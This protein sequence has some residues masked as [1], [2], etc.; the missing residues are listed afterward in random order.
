MDFSD[1]LRAVK[2]GRKA[3]RAAWGSFRTERGEAALELVQ[4]ISANDGRHIAPVLMIGYPDGTLRPF[5]GV[6]WDLMA[7]DWRVVDEA[8]QAG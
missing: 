1:A 2:D 8:G 3:T 4:V 5:A 7:G 6:N